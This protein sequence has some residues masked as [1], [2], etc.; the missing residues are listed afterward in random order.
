MA[1]LGIWT[2]PRMQAAQYA[3]SPLYE[4]G[5]PVCGWPP[6]MRSAPPNAGSPLGICPSLLY[7]GGPPPLPHADGPLVCPSLL[8]AAALAVEEKMEF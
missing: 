1:W 8:Y 3:G 7:A 2:W 5:C 4:V 6:R